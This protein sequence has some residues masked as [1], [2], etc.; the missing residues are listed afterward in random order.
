MSWLRIGGM[1]TIVAL[2]GCGEQQRYEYTTSDAVADAV[3]R[4]WVPQCVP[5]AARVE[6]EQNV[7]TNESWGVAM[8]AENDE[9][10]LRQHVIPWTWREANLRKPQTFDAWPDELL[11][12]SAREAA[13]QSIFQCVAESDFVLSIDWSSNRMFFARGTL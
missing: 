2:L 7:D 10:A 5:P 9:A 3:R 6:T 1:V 12:P 4:G 8:F 13:S 11:R